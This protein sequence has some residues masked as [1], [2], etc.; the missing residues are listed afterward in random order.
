MIQGLTQGHRL[1]LRVS[2]A[3]GFAKQTCPARPR[4]VA[5]W[6]KAFSLDNKAGVTLR[7]EFPPSDRASFWPM[8]KALNLEPEAAGTEIRVAWT[9]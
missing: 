6:T 3:V 7:T 5:L 8:I 9:S 1:N 2:C 4:C